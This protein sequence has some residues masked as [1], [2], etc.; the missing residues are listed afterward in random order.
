MNL[1]NRNYRK[2]G[3]NETENDHAADKRAQY[4]ICQ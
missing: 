2:E 3:I 4:R 1:Y